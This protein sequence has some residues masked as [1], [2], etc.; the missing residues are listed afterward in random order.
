MMPANRFL[1]IRIRYVTNAGSRVIMQAVD[2][3]MK[4][5]LPQTLELE[6]ELLRLNTLVRQ[7]RAQLERLEK[8]P[9]KSCECRAVWRQVVEENLAGQV[10]KIRRKIRPKAKSKAKAVKPKRA[11]A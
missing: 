3:G 7:R 11:R 1:A 8:C 5:K 6:A 2:V 10:G 9:N 4:S